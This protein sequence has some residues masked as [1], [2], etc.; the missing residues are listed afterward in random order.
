MSRVWSGSVSGVRFKGYFLF[1]LWVWTDTEVL[2]GSGLCIKPSFFAAYSLVAASGRGVLY[3][4]GQFA[5]RCFGVQCG[6]TVAD[7]SLE[8]IVK[9]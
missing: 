2:V 4:R 8:R 3:C 9:I 5:I 1:L 7:F 6:F